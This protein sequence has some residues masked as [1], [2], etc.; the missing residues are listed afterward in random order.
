MCNIVRMKGSDMDEKTVSY[1]MKVRITWRNYTCIKGGYYRKFWE[2]LIPF[3]PL[4]RN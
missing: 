3:F 4:I 2:E 1:Y